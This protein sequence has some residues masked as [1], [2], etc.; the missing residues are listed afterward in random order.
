MHRILMTVF[1]LGLYFFPWLLTQTAFALFQWIFM[2]IIF[3]KKS[4]REPI[5]HWFY[6]KIFKSLLV[7][8]FSFEQCK[9]ELKYYLCF[10]FFVT[11]RNQATIPHLKVVI[12][13]REAIII[14]HDF[15]TYL[16]KF[17]LLGKKISFLTCTFLYLSLTIYQLILWLMLNM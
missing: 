16:I 11:E 4:T 12:T 2:R 8:S 1:I 7:Q 9:K 17:L 5:A 14:F 10:F 6:F 13:N 15:L 3:C